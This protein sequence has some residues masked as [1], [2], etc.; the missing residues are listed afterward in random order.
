VETATDQDNPAR[1]VE[2]CRRFGEGQGGGG[3]GIVIDGNVRLIRV[4]IPGRPRLAYHTPV[5][6]YGG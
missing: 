6:S 3:I 1:A 5:D 4:A 2:L